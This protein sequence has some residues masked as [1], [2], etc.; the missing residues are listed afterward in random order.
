MKGERGRRKGTDG[1]EEAELTRGMGRCRWRG[2]STPVGVRWIPMEMFNTFRWILVDSVHPFPRTRFRW[3]P[4]DSGGFY[5][6]PVDS[7]GFR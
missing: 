4:D 2:R 5:W 1:E 3:I 6:I 7:G